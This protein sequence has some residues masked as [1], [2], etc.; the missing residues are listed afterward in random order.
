MADKISR[1]R[2][3]ANMRAIRSKGMKPELFVRRMVYSLG[4]RFRLHRKDLPG[5]PDL[6]FIGR[7]KAIFVN[8]CF[9]HQH[10]GCREGR[11]PRTN[12][13]YWAPKLRRNVERDRENVEQLSEKGWKSL[14]IWECETKHEPSLAQRLADFL[15]PPS[16]GEFHRR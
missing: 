5:K 2:R 12:Q 9:W 14:V 7:K 1:E 11:P 4:Y 13:E 3:S 16:I 6:A 10:P 8:G 15:G